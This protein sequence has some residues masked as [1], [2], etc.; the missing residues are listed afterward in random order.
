MLAEKSEYFW[1]RIYANFSFGPN[2]FGVMI[3]SVDAA[4]L[5]LLVN[6]KYIIIPKRC[7]VSGNEISMVDA[8]TAYFVLCDI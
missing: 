6:G 1:L 8:K 3:V 7:A 4:V 5:R 2:R